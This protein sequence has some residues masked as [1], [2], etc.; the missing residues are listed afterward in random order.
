MNELLLKKVKFGAEPASNEPEAQAP[1]E[2]NPEK[3]MNALTFMGIKNLMSNPKLAQEV[4]VPTEEPEAKADENSTKAKSYVAPYSSNIAFQGGKSKL[5]GNAIKLGTAALLAQGILS[6][7]MKQDVAV[8]V[9]MTAITELMSMM[10]AQLQ[11]MADNQEITNQRLFEMS[12]YMQQLLQMVKDGNLTQQQ[13]YEM[14]FNFMV[15]TTENQELIIAQLVK[16]GKSQDEANKLI[17]QLIDAVNNG[18]M[19]AEAAW[20]KILDLLG[21]INNTLLNILKEVINTRKEVEQTRT[22]LHNDNMVSLDYLS[23]LNAQ[24]VVLI[25]G[26]KQIANDIK[27]LGSKIDLSNT[28][29]ADIAKQL[30]ISES[31]LADLLREINGSINMNG[32]QIYEAIQS[33]TA[34]IKI[35]AGAVQELALEVEKGRM[36]QEAANK[37]ILALLNCTNTNVV[38]ILNELK[39][40]Y[41]NDAAMLAL[42]DKIYNRMGDLLN[43]QDTQIAEAGRQTIILNSILEMLNNGM[44]TDKLNIIID[45]LSQGNV[46][47]EKLMKLVC[48]LNQNVT[49]GRAENRQ[50]AADVLAALQ[51]LISQGNTNAQQNEEIIEQGATIINL[52]NSLQGSSNEQAEALRQLIQSFM[53][54]YTNGNNVTNS[55]LADILEAIGNIKLDGPTIDLSG[56]DAMLKEIISLLKTN[57]NLLSDLNAKVAL[58]NVSQS[59]IIDKLDGLAGKLPNYKQ[60]LNEI[61]ALLEALKNKPGYDDSRLAAKLDAIMEILLTH[62]F[63]NC[64]CSGSGNGNHEGVIDDILSCLKS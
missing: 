48:A 16:N 21:Q 61:K 56:F 27:G 22:V 62:Q 45:L 54:A 17:K 12:Q 52:I 1:A 18:T 4:G 53:N 35:L 25:N 8:E 15:Q 38:A 28:Y 58:I 64:N 5:A 37:Q 40:K 43:G 34:A 2:S 42:L 31:D 30:N 33:N 20:N 11:Q 24:L 41:H 63:C 60:D 9:D 39:N 13:F 6:S 26:Q 10:R 55:T 44:P 57:N 29:L 47:L 59:V 51:K 19:T 46:N 3:G 23:R 14:M 49:E 7:C 32:K 36:S 50:F